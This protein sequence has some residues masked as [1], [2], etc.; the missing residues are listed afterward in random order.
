MNP[1]YSAL[2]KIDPTDVIVLEF[3]C[4][5]N[6]E[7]KNKIIDLN[8]YEGLQVKSIPE[9]I[10]KLGFYIPY[11]KVWAGETIAQKC[12]DI[13][14]SEGFDKNKILMITE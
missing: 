2:I 13:L 3:S 8:Q 9:Y 1:T 6:S 12:F 14:I 10:G 7:T 5:L 11:S 4:P